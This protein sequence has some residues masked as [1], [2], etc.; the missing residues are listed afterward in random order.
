[1]AKKLGSYYVFRRAETGRL[2]AFRCAQRDREET[3]RD[4]LPT[5]LL[6]VGP[7][8]GRAA[9]VVVRAPNKADA[10]AYTKILAGK[11]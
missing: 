3:C 2:D 4:H 10:I 5:D 8:T 11:V 1:M 6:L 7:G 9:F